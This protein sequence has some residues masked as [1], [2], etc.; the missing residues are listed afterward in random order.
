MNVEKKRI[1]AD[2]L[3]AWEIA[4]G[5]SPTVEVWSTDDD[6]HPI[7]LGITERAVAGGCGAS[8]IL[9]LTPDEALRI[10][11]SLESHA[12]Q[13]G[14]ISDSEG[15]DIDQFLAGWHAAEESRD[16]KASP[17]Y[18]TA[19]FKNHLPKPPAAVAGFVDWLFMHA[20]DPKW[21]LM[22][23]KSSRSWTE[24]QDL[25]AAKVGFRWPRSGP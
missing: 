15:D 18:V 12:Q 6:T 11:E 21:I 10:G 13:T 23:A 24:A 5:T 1:G 22:L 9:H 8:T 16:P 7:S 20:N 4:H 3:T 17:A 25:A 19:I 14:A 2:D